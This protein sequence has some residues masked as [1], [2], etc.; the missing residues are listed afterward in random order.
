MKNLGSETLHHIEK[1]LTKKGPSKQDS[2]KKESRSKSPLPKKKES[3]SPQRPAHALYQPMEKDNSIINQQVKLIYNEMEHQHN[4]K[5]QNKHSY[6]LNAKHPR[7]PLY[8]RAQ[9]I[10]KERDLWL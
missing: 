7:P 6:F 2:K 10:V 1:L 4:Y 3:P 8:Q 5:V 9:E